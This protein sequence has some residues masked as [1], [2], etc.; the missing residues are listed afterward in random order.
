M[1]RHLGRIFTIPNIVVILSAL[2]I[3]F[4]IYELPSKVKALQ[5]RVATNE[6]EII[7]L[8]EKMNLN[9]TM[10]SEVRADVKQILKD[11]K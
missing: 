10:L 2:Y 7:V 1:K 3:C 6:R 4:Q 8:K 9:L 5:D 11:V